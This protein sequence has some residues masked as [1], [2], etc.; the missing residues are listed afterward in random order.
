[1]GHVTILT[2]DIDAT[3]SEIDNTGIWRE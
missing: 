1:M 3:L 2:D